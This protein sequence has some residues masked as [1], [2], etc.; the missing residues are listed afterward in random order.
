MLETS[1]RLLKL[2]SLLQAHRDWSGTDLAERLGVTARTVRRDV[3]RLRELGYP[4]HA[5]QGA[6]GYRLGAGAALPPLLLDDDE[7]VAVAVG[8]RT[9]TSSSVAG[10]E[11]TALRALTKLEQVLPSRLRHRVNTVQTATVRAG[12]APGPQ[13]SADTLM[14]I[15]DACRRHERL[16]FD[17]TGPRGGASRR[18]AE[19]YSLVNFGRHWYLVAFD[20]DRDDWRT[21]RVDRLDPRPPAGPRFTPRDLPYD[22]VAAYLADRLSARAWACQATVR[23]HEPAD[24]VAGRVWPGMGAV[25]AVDSTSCLLHL[26][27]ETATDLVWMITSVQ[28]DFTLVSGPPELAGAFRRQARRCLDALGER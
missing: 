9:A 15:A 23:L 25:E 17:Y 13:V 7:A 28:A 20:V 27:A 6:P 1:A 18:N 19:P 16:R 2:L 8:L 11:E 26:G 10:I 4:V 3:E 22:D 24:A 21:F 12:V 5:L 14:T